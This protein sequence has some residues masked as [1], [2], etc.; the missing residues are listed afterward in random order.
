MP[1]ALI[2]NTDSFN[3]F[4]KNS[5]EGKGKCF[6]FVHNYSYVEIETSLYKLTGGKISQDSP[7]AIIV[8]NY[9]SAILD[10]FNKIKFDNIHLAEISKILNIGED[11]LKEN[12]YPLIFGNGCNILEKVSRQMD[13]EDSILVSDSVKINT[14]FNSEKKIIN[15]VNTR[16]NEGFIRK[17]KISG[18]R[19]S[20]IEAN[21]VKIMKHYKSLHH[22]DL[23]EKVLKA[24][25]MFKIN[26]SVIKIFFRIIIYLYFNLIIFRNF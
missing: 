10:L 18:E 5:V 23:V 21:I 25:E 15:F 8:N 6:K 2:A 17:E 24:L 22:H 9:Q 26:I 7:M 20:A 12:I 1:D 3:K 11:D 16:K 13:T 14:N 19:S 4:Y